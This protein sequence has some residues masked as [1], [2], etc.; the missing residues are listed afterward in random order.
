MVGII[1]FPFIIIASA[2]FLLMFMLE[3]NNAIDFYDYVCVF[4]KYF[5]LN[6]IYFKLVS[7][8]FNTKGNQKFAYYASTVNGL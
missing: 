8:A 5:N 3:R 4:L 1:F 2:Q 7:I 6:V